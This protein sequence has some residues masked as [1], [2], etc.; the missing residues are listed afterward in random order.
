M[1]DLESAYDI[2]D[3]LLSVTGAAIMT[4]DF[5]RFAP[6]FAVPMVTESFQGQRNVRTR[7][8]LRAVFEAAADFYALHNV[9]DLVRRVVSAEFATPDIIHT[10]H[11]A[12]LLSRQIMLDQQ[13]SCFSRIRRFDGVWR[14]DLTRYANV[15]APRLDAI[16]SVADGAGTQH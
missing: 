13:T 3:H 6:Y 9:T 7:E 2:A 16:F 5:L 15:N 14:I 12:R 4:R 10:V 1:T 11:E 8:E